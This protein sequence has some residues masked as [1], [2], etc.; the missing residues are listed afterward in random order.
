M[1]DFGATL[2]E[3]GLT[4]DGQY[5]NVALACEP[6]DYPRQRTYLG[7]IVGRFAN[8]IGGSRLVQ[9]GRE[10]ILSANEGT[11]CLRRS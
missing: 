5:R 2:T 11:T 8:R 1:L 10:W 4:V 6:A 9:D 3:L 7:A